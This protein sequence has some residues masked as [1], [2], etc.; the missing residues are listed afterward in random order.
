MPD[1]LY[2][3]GNDIPEQVL[4]NSVDR[5]EVVS[6]SCSE[7]SVKDKLLVNFGVT[8]RSHTTGDTLSQSQPMPK[9]VDRDEGGWSMVSRPETNY[10]RLRGYNSQDSDMENPQVKA[11]RPNPN[12]DEEFKVLIKVKGGAGFATVSPLKL[13]NELKKGIGDIL[14]TSILQNGMISIIYKSETS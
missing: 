3:S 12:S 1:G 9:G 2:R 8:I 4:A 7:F 5:F 10:K 13:T 11:I 14:H 6:K